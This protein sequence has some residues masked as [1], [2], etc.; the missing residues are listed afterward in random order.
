[1]GRIPPGLAAGGAVDA[2]SGLAQWR[3]RRSGED[4]RSGRRRRWE[5]GGATSQD[6]SWQVAAGHTAGHT[7]EY[8][9]GYAAS[10]TPEAASCGWRRRECGCE[11][12]GTIWRCTGGSGLTDS[13]RGPWTIAKCTQLGCV[14]QPA[15][16]A[17]GEWIGIVATC[18]PEDTHKGQGVRWKVGG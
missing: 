5:Q 15:C 1:M 9:V 13:V 8:A 14:T 3:C 10:V 7:A 2:E 11:S 12:G 4:A 6:A 17:A 18:A 16:A